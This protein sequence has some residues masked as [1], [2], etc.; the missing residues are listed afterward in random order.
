MGV[1]GA[2]MPVDPEAVVARRPLTG[3]AAAY[4]AAT[5][6]CVELRDGRQLVFKHLP[7]EGDWLT[8]VTAGHG[9]ARRLWDEGVLAKV[10]ATVDHTVVD[11]M[12]E[13]DRDVVAMRDAA[14]SLMSAVGPVGRGR[15]RRL[16]AGLA[17]LHQGWSGERIDGLCSLSARYRL[18]TPGFHAAYVGQPGRHVF[19]EHFV[20][21]WDVFADL[22]P[23]DIVEA[24]ATVH[25]DPSRLQ[26]RL[27]TFPPVLLHGDTKMANLGLGPNGWV[28]VDWGELTGF[29]PVEVDVAWYAALN[30]GQIGGSPGDVFDDYQAVGGR[31]DP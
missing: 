18:F 22:A 23:A 2:V 17:G 30:A 4:S 29:G 19:A 28:A 6:E 13:G 12:T 10:A 16:L 24:I 27:E 15:S 9:R 5:L 31:L 11:V 3:A 14:A 1:M 25:R 26:Q 8:R 21:S 7:A 20:A